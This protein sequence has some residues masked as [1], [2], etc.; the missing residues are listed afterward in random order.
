MCGANAQAGPAATHERDGRA[1]ASTP[2]ANLRSAGHSEPGGAKAFDG[3]ES[4]GHNVDG[5]EGGE[6]Q[7]HVAAK[8]EDALGE[9]EAQVNAVGVNSDGGHGGPFWSMSL[10]YYHV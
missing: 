4:V 2:R 5:G 8:G 10:Y 9:A 3:G 6:R 7:A 1:A